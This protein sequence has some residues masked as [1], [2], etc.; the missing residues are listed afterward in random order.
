MDAV[1]TIASISKASYAL[2]GLIRTALLP[3]LERLGDPSPGVSQAAEEV[4]DVV[5]ASCGYAGLPDLV[6]QNLDYIVDSLCVQLRDLH[7]DS[8]CV[9][10]ADTRLQR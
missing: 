1:G 2:S 5:C 4:M 7:A 8:R 9:T 6:A 10:M 3:L